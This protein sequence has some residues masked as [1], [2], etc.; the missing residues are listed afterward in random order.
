MLHFE[1][2][3]CNNSVRVLAQVLQ[4][5]FMYAFG[6]QK[7]LFIALTECTEPQLRL[8]WVK[9]LPTVAAIYMQS[10]KPILLDNSK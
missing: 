10:F 6:N 4:M 5:Q 7:K 9:I 2:I 3:E 1:C 8:T